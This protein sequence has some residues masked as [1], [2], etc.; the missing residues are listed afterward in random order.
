MVDFDLK[1]VFVLKVV[2][3]WNGCMFFL[4]YFGDVVVLDCFGW[5]ECFLFVLFM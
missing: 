3:L 2:E 4:C 1:M 5:L